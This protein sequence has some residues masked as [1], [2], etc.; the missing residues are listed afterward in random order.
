[1]FPSRGGAYPPPDELFAGRYAVDGVLPWGGLSSYYRASAE[2]TPLILNIMPMDVGKSPKAE[3]AFSHLAQSLGAIHSQAVPKVLDAGTIDGVPYIAFQETRGTLLTDVLRERSLGSLTVLRLATDVL[4][5]LDAV[6]AQGLVHGD[7]TPQNI[8][9]TRNR[10]GRF[11]AR[12]IGTGVLP[13]L[14]AN[15]NAS[16]HAANTGSGSHS[17]AYMAP[18][19]FGGGDFKPSADLYSVGALLHHMVVGTPPIG[20]ESEEG[21]DDLP[22][23]PDVIRRAMASRPQ[24]RYPSATSMRT[25]LEWIEAESAKQ[26]PQTQDIAPWMETSFVGSIPVPSIAST[27]PPTH[28]SSSHPA[29]RILSTSGVRAIPV[30]PIVIEEIDPNVERRWVQIVLLL[31]L[32]G[33]L[34]VAGYWYDAQQRADESLAPLGLE[35]SAEDAE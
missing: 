15:P 7:L 30:E 19:L 27:H 33:T 20:W 24:N 3:A 26:N 13:L 5:A 35:P 23:L 18:E 8:I 10:N 17:V 16:A 6:H 29:G 32:L 22:G 11:S 25:A 4:N 31:L 14:R 12:L 1:M 21:F 2:G 28:V 9:V 34:A